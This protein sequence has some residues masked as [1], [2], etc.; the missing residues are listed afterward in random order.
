MDW[1]KAKNTWKQVWYFIWED[2]SWASWFVNVILAF[3]L[4]KFVVYPTLGL[5]LAT[6][7]PIVAVVSSSMEHDGGFE[8]WWQQKANCEQRYDCTQGRFYFALGYTKENFQEFRFSNGFN[9]G[10]IMI[11]YRTDPSLLNVG[12]VIVFNA[13]RPDPIIH[14][15]IIIEDGEKGRL[16]TTKGD[17]NPASFAFETG[18]MEQ[19]YIGKAVVRIPWV[20]YIKI[21][22]VRLMQIIGV[23]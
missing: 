19:N 4:I 2:D 12:D 3:V 1:K 6:T 11:L 23:L 15:I 22:F 10:D 17:N 16:F 14:R 8:Y 13:G 18:I 20:G 7:H 5:V 9:K 21:S